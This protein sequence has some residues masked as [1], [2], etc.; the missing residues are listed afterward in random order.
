VDLHRCREIVQGT[1]AAESADVSQRGIVFATIV[2]S[3]VAALL[4]GGDVNRVTSYGNPTRDAY[5]V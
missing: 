5:R 2:G 4:I 1:H 3:T